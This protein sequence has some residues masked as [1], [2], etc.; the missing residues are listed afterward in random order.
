MNDVPVEAGAKDDS[1]VVRAQDVGLSY[2]KAHALREVNLDIP[3]GCMVGLI[4][5]DGVGK[6]SLLSL[7]AGARTMQQGRIEV[8]GGDISDKRH[9]Q[10]AY[11][12]IAYMPQGLG[13]N[14]YPTLS[15]FENIDFFG[16]LFGPN[17]KERERRIVDLLA[18]TG[19]S[20]FADRPAG[21]LSGG[22]KQKTSLCCSLIHDPDLLILDEP[23]T[24]VD[25]LSRRQF[26]EL[27]DDIRKDRPG[28]SVIVATAYMEEAERFDWL[29]AMNDGQIL[30][31]GTPHE[32]LQRTN[33][34]NLD[35]AFI[36]LLPE[37]LRKGHQDIEIPHRDFGADAEIA[38]EA[39]HVTVRFGNFTAV[40]DVSFRI[41]RGEIFGFL[42]SN[43]CG[44]TTTMKVLTGLL[45][46]SEGTARL[47]GREV[48]PKDID[49]RRHV[50]Y[51]SQAFSLY[52][53]LTVRQN[54]ELHAKLFDMAPDLTERRIQELTERFDLIEVMDSLPDALPLGIRQ[55]LTLAVAL[56]H[57]PDI[58]ILDEPTSGVDPVARD[59]FWQILADLSRTD[60]VTIF[61]STH[62]MNEAELCDRISLMHAGKVLISD[63]PK[64]ITESRHA[65]TLEE[66]FVAYLQDA[67]GETEQSAPSPA[68]VPEQITEAGET[69]PKKASSWMPDLR[70]MLAYTRREALELKRDPIRATLAILGS[71]ILMF[72]IG[73]GI[74][75]DVE[76]LK[77][78]V[79]DRDDTTISRDYTQQIAGSRYFSEQPPITDYDD[80]DRRMRDGEISLAI[81]IPPNFAADVM[82]GRPVE[83]AAWIDGAMPTRAETIK[84]Y[85]QGMHANWLT[86]KARELYGS[87]ANVGSFNLEIRYRYNPDVQSLVAMVPA[88]IP[89][90]LL[91]IPSMLAVLSVVREKELGSIIN[92]Y[93]TPVTKFEF[94]FGKQLPYIGLAFLNFL[95]LTAF[96]VF[97]FRVPFT[98]SFPT[99]ALAA[100]L[101]V[102]IATGMGLVLSTFMNSQIAAIFGTALL[103]LIPAVQYSG[104]IDP[105]SSLQGAGAFIGKIYPATYF[106]TISRG[107]FS[108]ALGFADLAGSFLPLLIA[109]PVLMALAIVLLKKQAS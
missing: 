95:M 62:F 43:G 104:I 54:L 103:T 98:G 105:V 74:N 15:V 11:P 64:A 90:L 22:M 14:L 41:P 55:R 78:A 50:G 4:G 106:V 24:G 13:K 2:E 17:R 58:L 32:L 16:R 92:F 1:F 97:I 86:Q 107:V 57:S 25:P 33:T 101:Y 44:K 40:N 71:V 19:M 65:E 93:V 79:L 47:F 59:A 102:T 63:T 61:V 81:E 31:T 89:L 8:L 85:V 20:A 99:Y 26:W 5:P 7:V 18:R 88:V 37:E 29:V 72:V 30:A 76:N 51:M 69:H 91:M 87:A 53:E 100:L 21:K 36:A 12:R 27:I 52:S 82:R 109:V 39:E 42:G 48:D 84:G 46:A 77:F 35:A 66:A 60:N 23:T 3:A 68:I 94:L 34:P 45:P 38:I 9:L 70:R 67:I 49:I 80:L 6:S 10:S 73:Y 56:I 28:M 108:K 83:V 75:L 96:A